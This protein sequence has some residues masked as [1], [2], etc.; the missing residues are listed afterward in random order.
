MKLEEIYSRL[1]KLGIPVAYL[2]FDKPQTPPFA[3]YY[4]SGGEV[5][6]ADECNL[7]RNTNITVEL[8]TS[9]KTP[10]LERHLEELFNDVPLDK[11]TDSYIENEKL[12]KIEYSFSTIETGG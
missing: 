8:Y 5:N 4:E 11:S 9:K 2:I 10:E 1:K 6:G 7:Y 3:V 12:L